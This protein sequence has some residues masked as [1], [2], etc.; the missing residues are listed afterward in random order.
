MNSKKCKNCGLTNFP[1]DL[2]CR[3]CGLIFVRDAPKKRQGSPARFSVWSLLMIAAV[4]GVVYYFYTGVQASMDEI[5][6]NEAKRLATQP[7][8]KPEQQGLSRTQ[9]DQQRAGTYADAVKNSASLNAHQ[10]RV[11]E[12]EKA[13]KQLSNSK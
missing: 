5:D 8:P 11:E 1:N 2:E 3:R 4:L 9:Y 13:V 10:K 6:R 12:T 7:P